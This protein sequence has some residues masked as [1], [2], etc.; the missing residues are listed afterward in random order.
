MYGASILVDAK[1]LC[2][3]FPTLWVADYNDRGQTMFGQIKIRSY[4][5]TGCAIINVN[6][7]CNNCVPS[8]RIKN[9]L[10]HSS[11]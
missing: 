1:D 8:S 7:A 2:Y 9:R 4:R 6:G 3:P 10:A 11:I 5:V